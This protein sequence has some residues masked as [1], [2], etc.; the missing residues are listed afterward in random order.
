MAMARKNKF[1]LTSD[2]KKTVASQEQRV[3]EKTESKQVSGEKYQSY[4]VLMEKGLHKRLRFESYEEDCSMNEIIQ[5]ALSKYL[6]E[7][8][9]AESSCPVTMK[10]LSKRDAK[11]FQIRIPMDIFSDMKKR[12]IETYESYNYMIAKSLA[13]YF[14]I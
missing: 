2:A 12:K 3:V 5:R 7:E 13:K 8:P 9:V 1:D 6:K 10:N 14:D 4:N 11:K